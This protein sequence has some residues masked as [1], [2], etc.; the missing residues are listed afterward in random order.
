MCI[1]ATYNI[2]SDM[3]KT[4]TLTESELNKIINEHV[5]NIL[6]EYGIDIDSATKTVG[7]NPNH[8]EYIDTNDSWNPKPIYNE[9]NGYKVISVFERKESDDKLDGNPLIYALKGKY[10]WQLKNPR[11]DYMALMRRFIAVCKE[12]N[13]EY[14]VIIVTPSST[15]LNIEI[16]HKVIE[17]IPHK[18]HFERFFHKEDAKTVFADLVDIGFIERN[19]DEADQDKMYKAFALSF[20]RMEKENN[21]IF[22]YKYINPIRL[23]GAVLNSMSINHDITNDAN[24]YSLIDNKK[25][26]II[27]DTVA[28]GKTIS[29]SAEALCNVFNPSSVTFFTLFSP[30]KMN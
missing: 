1:F 18:V 6:N 30:L 15:S 19:F 10:N 28:S 9:I 22:S 13:E 24:I 25:V 16:L 17:F 11:Y 27:D 7:F 12:L 23:R 21:G 3:S 14:D 5:Y 4:I 29:D 8:Q 2:T 20:K 26:L